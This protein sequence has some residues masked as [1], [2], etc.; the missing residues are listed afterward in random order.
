[1][2]IANRIGWLR[3][4]STLKAFGTGIASGIE[5]LGVLFVP[6][7]FLLIQPILQYMLLTLQSGS[8]A[9]LMAERLVQMSNSILYGALAI[10]LSSSE[11]CFALSLE[12]L[13]PYHRA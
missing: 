11:L 5:V 3:I 10:H 6:L 4:N 12:L 1:M 8:I 2:I 9:Y 7:H 13:H